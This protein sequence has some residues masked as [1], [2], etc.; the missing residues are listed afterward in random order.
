MREFKL[1]EV[2]FLDLE[3]KVFVDW[4]T[5][6]FG[7]K[8][9]AQALASLSDI[10]I[11]KHVDAADSQALFV[12]KLDTV[13]YEFE[14]AV[15]D[16]FD[17]ARY[18]PNDP[19]HEDY[20]LLSVKEVMA[21]WLD[22]FPSD[23][24]TSSTQ[25]GQCRL[26]ITQNK[27]MPFTDQVSRLRAKFSRRDT[28]VTDGEVSY[29]TTPTK[30]VS[31]GVTLSRGQRSS[32]APNATGAA[33]RSAGHAANSAPVTPRLTTGPGTGASARPDRT[34]RP[35]PRPQQGAASVPGRTRITPG[36]KRCQGCGAENNHWG[37]GYTKDSCPAFGTAY[38][39]KAGHVWL[40]SSKMPKVNIPQPEYQELLRSN[41]RIQQNWDKARSTTRA[42]VMALAGGEDV[43]DD[44]VYD[45][46]DDVAGEIHDANESY[47]TVASDHDDSHEVNEINCS[48][49]ARSSGAELAQLSTDD[50]LV[51]LGNMQ[52][53]FA[54]SRLA[55]NDE[56]VAK[57]L[58]DPGATMNIIS[59]LC[60]NRCM[61]DRRHVQVNIFQ[62]KRKVCTVEEIAKCCFELK[63]IHGKWQKHVQWFGVHEI[64]YEMLLG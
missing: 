33:P 50:A 13:A 52:Q 30:S 3:D 42:S 49:F 28:R 21:K 64:G 9:K 55:G 48:S 60:C 58:M 36:H 7:P 17:M 39:V 4:L 32:A 6:F 29:T 44:D 26:F 41:P 23:Q 25:I 35:R 20:G 10:K 47:D 45:Y 43:Y 34:D 2:L 40:D 63:D 46:N 54:V 31:S 62:G 51:L 1:T 8:H 56:F 18:W 15:N 61:V 37:L 5:I 27:E 57:T 53:F 14:L 38:A 16:I 12:P 11:A 19:T 24:A 59:P 22:S